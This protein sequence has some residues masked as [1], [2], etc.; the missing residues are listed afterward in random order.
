MNKEDTMTPLQEQNNAFV[1]D[2]ADE[3]GKTSEKEL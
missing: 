3:A 1:L 2:Y